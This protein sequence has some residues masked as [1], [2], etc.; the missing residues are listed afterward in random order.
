MLTW[1]RCPHARTYF[2]VHGLKIEVVP[3]LS[4]IVVKP[5]GASAIH[6]IFM[7]LLRLHIRGALTNPK[8]PC[9]E[10]IHFR[11]L[12]AITFFLWA[13]SI[14]SALSCCFT[15]TRWDHYLALPTILSILQQQ[16]L[17]YYCQF[18]LCAKGITD[19]TEVRLK[20]GI[21]KPLKWTKAP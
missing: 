10:C 6:D 9:T 8:G 21:F 15:Y 4:H 20:M 11:N 7:E 2:T 12:S 5:R 1:G 16:K 17:I 13:I 18:P 19:A 14:R 3:N